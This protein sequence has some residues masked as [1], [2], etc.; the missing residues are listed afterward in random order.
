MDSDN[1]GTMAVCFIHAAAVTYN[2][3]AGQVKPAVAGTQG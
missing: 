2:H 3:P 1:V